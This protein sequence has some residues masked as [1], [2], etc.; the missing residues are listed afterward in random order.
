MYWKKIQKGKIVK[1]CAS[2]SQCYSYV[3]LES[4]LV[5]RDRCPKFQETLIWDNFNRTLILR[6]RLFWTSSVQWNTSKWHLT[7]LRVFTKVILILGESPR[8][9]SHSLALACNSG[10]TLELAEYQC[11]GPILDQLIQYL[12]KQAFSTV[13][14]L[15]L[16]R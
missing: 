4:V 3:T 2:V 14:F 11:L 1:L 16:S 8:A 9:L 5:T 13:I 15:K 12:K 7:C 10:C 6:I